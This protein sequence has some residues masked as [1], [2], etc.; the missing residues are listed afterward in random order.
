MLNIIFIIITCVR[1][2]IVY[3]NKKCNYSIQ[4]IDTCVHNN[5]ILVTTASSRYID[6]VNRLATSASGIFNCVVVFYQDELTRSECHNNILYA[7][8]NPVLNPDPFWCKKKHRNIWG[9]ARSQLYKTYAIHT[10]LDMNYNVMVMDVDYLVNGQSFAMLNTAVQNNYDIV[11]TS[12]DNM[13][14]KYQPFFK[15]K[16]K[17]IGYLNFGA[18]WMRATHA[19]RQVMY[20]VY[21]RTYRAWDQYLWNIEFDAASLKCCIARNNLNLSKNEQPNKIVKNTQRFTCDEPVGI[22]LYPP[23]AKTH[24]ILGVSHNEW[25]PHSYNEIGWTTKRWTTR[26]TQFCNF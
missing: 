25:K 11:G 26:C 9:W 2:T 13:S 6:S 20:R 4:K 10:M 19:T 24:N 1:S 14:A 7:T 17:A 12:V 16:K 21:N 15:Q 22:S 3:G 8:L 23:V 5:T 18:I